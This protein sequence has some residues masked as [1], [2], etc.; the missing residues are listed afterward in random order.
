MLCFQKLDL[1]V[2]Q[3]MDF[4]LFPQNTEECSS[5]RVPRT[6][7]CVPVSSPIPLAYRGFNPFS[8]VERSE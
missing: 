4:S 2:L 8:G 5:F 1:K 6:A 3:V 7:F